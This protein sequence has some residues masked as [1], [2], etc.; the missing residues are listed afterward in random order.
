[1]LTRF[2]PSTIIRPKTKTLS[3]LLV[4]TDDDVKNARP[5]RLSGEKSGFQYIT[6]TEANGIQD[7]TAKEIA[8]FDFVSNGEN[9]LSIR[10]LNV[11]VAT[12]NSF[13]DSH[14][15]LNSLYLAELENTG[16]ESSLL[17]AVAQGA[18]TAT[19]FC[20]SLMA[21]GI[22]VDDCVIGVVSNTGINICFGATILLEDSF[23]IYIPLSKQLDLLDD[24]E[25]RVASAY[26]QKVATHARN[27]SRAGRMRP[28]PVVNDMVLNL[29]RY[30]VK[31]LTQEV[32]DRGIG[33]F[34]RSGD[35]TDVHNGVNHMIRCLN[36]LYNSKAR[37]VAEYPLTIRTP[38]SSSDYFELIYRDLG[39]LGFVSGTPNRM[40]EPEVF[41]TFVIELKRCV[42]LVHSAGV[43][44]G[45]LYASNIMWSRT[46]ENDVIIKI[47]DWD[48]SHCLEEGG[49]N[50][51]IH[52]ILADRVY[53]GQSVSFGVCHDLKYISVYE[54]PLEERHHNEWMELASGQKERIDGAFQ[55]L[56]QES[57]SRKMG[58]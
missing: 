7:M 3:Y 22:P 35:K 30:F 2:D 33:L 49:F 36:L 15:Q 27:L 24:Y 56:M 21:Q 13:N 5:L 43:I 8:R 23:P 20:I 1:M 17:P 42:D 4:P 58:K 54:M 40:T 12:G 44:H 10:G 37:D 38:D 52:K 50:E 26:L 9:H 55:T 11:G 14:I 28:P 31:T 41:Q 39:P 34:T 6:E 53:A 51:A 19:N 25:S 47:V 29:E 32:F 18:A 16:A 46:V 45:D 57:M 48:A